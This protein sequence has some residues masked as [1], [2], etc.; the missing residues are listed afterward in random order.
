MEPTD[1]LMRAL[2]RI[3]GKLDTVLETH[4][5]HSLRLRSLETWRNFERG[6]FATI[7]AAASLIFTSWKLH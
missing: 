3:E 4:T 5:D 2:G 1:D 7:G 6:I